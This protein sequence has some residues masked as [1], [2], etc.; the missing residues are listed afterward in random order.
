MSTCQVIAV[1]QPEL[2]EGITSLIVLCCPLP[3]TRG[4]KNLLGFKV[5]GKINIIKAKT[6]FSPENAFRYNFFLY[7]EM[8]SF[9]A[10][11]NVS[12]RCGFFVLFCSFSGR[13]PAITSCLL[14]LQPEG[15]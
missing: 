2:N 12:S 4:L 1:M 7:F 8:S 9:I 5:Y 11:K 10:D 15:C 14:I 3:P 13:S 6:S